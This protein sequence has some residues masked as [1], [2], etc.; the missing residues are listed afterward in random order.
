MK[1][2]KMYV[3]GE[4]M[5]YHTYYTKGHIPFEEF[6]KRF[7]KTFSKKEWYYGSD[8]IKEDRLTR[9]NARQR[10]ANDSDDY[11]F[12]VDFDVPQKQGAFL[13]TVMDCP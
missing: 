10:P 8:F 13:V 5:E 2:E 11:D 6:V 4:D 12:W 3:L 7:K 9:T 1:D